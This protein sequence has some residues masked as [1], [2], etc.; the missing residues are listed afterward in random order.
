MRIEQEQLKAE[1]VQKI[2][3]LSQILINIASLVDEAAFCLLGFTR[4][5]FETR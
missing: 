5:V 3:D 4:F 1:F 2:I